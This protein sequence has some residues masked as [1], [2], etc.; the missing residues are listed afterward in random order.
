MKLQVLLIWYKA[1]TN[2][3]WWRPPVF[4][5]GRHHQSVTSTNLRGSNATPPEKLGE[6][7]L[8]LLPLFQRPWLRGRFFGFSP[9]RGHTLH[10]SRWNMAVRSG[11]YNIS[12]PPCHISPWSAHG[13]GFTALKLWKFGILL[14]LLPLRAG[15]LHDSYKIYRVALPQL[16]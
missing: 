7:P 1:D 14:I 4:T 11:P 13:Y 2:E 8:T 15:P 10:R 16:I 5:G 9:R 3:C 12:S 6:Q